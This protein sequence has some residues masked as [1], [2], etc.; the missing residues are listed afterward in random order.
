[1]SK[2]NV[3]KLSAGIAKIH[4]GKDKVSAPASAGVTP[5]P[6]KAAY[7]QKHGRAV[8]NKPEAGA[9]DN[10]KD[11][12]TATHHIR[13]LLM[14]TQTNTRLKK[15]ASTS[16]SLQRALSTRTVQQPRSANE[17]GARLSCGWLRLH[18]LREEGCEETSTAYRGTLL[19]SA[20]HCFQQ[21]SDQR[22]G[23]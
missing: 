11:S 10:G 21:H 5:H 8:L 2:D 17:F 6:E 22:Q 1:M 20:L 16:Q 18:T 14:S 15:V 4:S 13:A 7:D 19:E 23:Q 3:S 12:K 9:R